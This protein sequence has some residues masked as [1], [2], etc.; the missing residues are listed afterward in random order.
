MYNA[1][2]ATPNCYAVEELE[3]EVTPTVYDD[4]KFVTRDELEK[5]G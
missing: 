1:P 3:E 2:G 5:L 4:Y